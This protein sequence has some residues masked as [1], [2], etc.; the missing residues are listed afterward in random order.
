MR[1]LLNQLASLLRLFR[2]F[3]KFSFRWLLWNW[4]FYIRIIKSTWGWVFYHSWWWWPQVLSFYA[5]FSSASSPSWNCF[6]WGTH[7]LWWSVSYISGWSSCLPWHSWWSIVG[8]IPSLVLVL[9]FQFLVSL[10]F[11]HWNSILNYSSKDEK[12]NKNKNLW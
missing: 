1:Q 3:L 12:P 6:S 8:E 7:L 2:T 5:N 4:W 11:L 10:R 9:L